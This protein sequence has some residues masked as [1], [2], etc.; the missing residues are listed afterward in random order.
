MKVC[1]IFTSI[2]GES[3]YAGLPCTF[4]RMSGCNLR[5]SYCDTKYSYDEGADLS[6]E[7]VYAIVDKTAIRLI[8]IT[9]GEPLL[10]KE[11]VARLT[12]LL[13]DSGYSVLMETNG[14]LPIGEI[15]NR[16]IVIM[17]VKT[18]ASGMSLKNDFTNF[19]HLKRSDEV[20]FV[21]C[22]KNDYIW[23]RRVVMEEGLPGRCE[24]LFAPAFGSLEPRKLAEWIIADRLPVRLNV[25]LHKYIFGTDERL[26]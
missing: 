11:D 3:T 10:Q 25:Q 14:T 22:N 7:N 5:C 6:V 9:G 13:L 20:K 23:A 16:V 12:A 19:Q 21:I 4:V 18:P 1:E 26:V 8:E 15:D 24:V 17:D 2:Q